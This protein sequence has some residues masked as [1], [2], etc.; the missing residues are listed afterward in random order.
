MSG[1][2]WPSDEAWPVMEPHLPKARPSI[3]GEI[4]IEAAA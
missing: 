2:D 4:S 3:P 1:A